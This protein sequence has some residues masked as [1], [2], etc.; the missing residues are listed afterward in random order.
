M[1]ISGFVILLVGN[2]FL[3]LFSLW[4]FRECAVC[5]QFSSY[6][7]LVFSQELPAI[8]GLGTG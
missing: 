3:G 8:G 2:L 4:I 5:C 1:L 7:E 6:V